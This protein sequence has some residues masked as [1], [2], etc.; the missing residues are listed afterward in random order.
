MEEEVVALDLRVFCHQRHDCSCPLMK[1][2]LG[3]ESWRE[4]DMSVPYSVSSLA[5]DELREEECV[6]VASRCWHHLWEEEVEVWM[7]YCL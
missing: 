2:P 6:C 7:K 5:I 1:A 3:D 4:P